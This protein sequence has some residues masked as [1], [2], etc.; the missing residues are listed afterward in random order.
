MS[1]IR[2]QGLPSG[3]SEGGEVRCAGEGVESRLAAS[4]R[5]DTRSQAAGLNGVR[6]AS[7]P[8]TAG[9]QAARNPNRYGY[10]RV[11]I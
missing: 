2:S 4:H 5:L 10:R 11:S 1:L 3:E 7:R 6:T 8:T 9:V